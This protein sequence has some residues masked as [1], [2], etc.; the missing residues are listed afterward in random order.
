MKNFTFLITLLLVSVTNVLFPQ[1]AD[2]INAAID[3][4][5]IA[6]LYNYI[7]KGPEGTDAKLVSSATSAVRRYT[8]IDSSTQK[9]RTGKMDA[10]VRNVGKDLMD[11][12]FVDPQSAL[13][14]VTTKLVTGVGDQFLKVKIIHDWICDTIAYDAEMYFSGRIR[15]QDY[16]S[17]LKKKA[18][19]CS[20]YVSVFNEMCRLA[21]IGSIGISGYSKGFGYGGTIGGQTD[22]EWNA[23]KLNG[24]WYL[25]DVTWDAGN[26]DRRTFIKN[27]SAEWLFLDSRPFLYSHLP[28]EERYQFYAPVLTANDFMREAYIAGK[29]FQYGLALTSENPGYNNLI[30]DGFTFELAARN[31]NVSLSNAVRTPQQ[32]NVTGVAW[33]DKKGTT[34]TLD[35][36]VPDTAE[37]RGHVFARYNNEI[38]LQDRIAI[39]TFE[40][41]WLPRAEAFYNTKNPKDRKITER[42]LQLFKDSYFKVAD[43]GAYY[44]AED[45]FDTARNNAV[46]KI[47]KL[48]ELQTNW[49]ENILGFNIKA[50][51]GYQGFGVN[52]QKYPFTYPSYNDVSNTQLISPLKGV[53][54]SGETEVFTMTSK[55]FT[56]FAIIINGQFNPL[57]KD[58]AGNFEL[59]F[60]IPAEIE[61]LE[62]FGSKNGRQYT[63]IIRYDVVQ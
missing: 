27:Y 58:K 7:Q 33:I 34:F 2:S 49:L 41:D 35:F 10:R 24:K 19:V 48:L 61:K 39:G 11:K 12:V 20:G 50:A 55:D 17:V 6:V 56:N 16:V 8:T 52:A 62:L 53:L 13:P 1:T 29:F 47:H 9:Y 42:E 45:Q 26:L 60:E 14:D 22:H 18:G 46:L 25:V 5:N 44:F 57:S 37:Y 30:H 59:A 21:G 43:N 4:G 28:E 63:G 32:R 51:P 38:R 3:S 36:D 23:V 54:K 15:N 31:A 40:G